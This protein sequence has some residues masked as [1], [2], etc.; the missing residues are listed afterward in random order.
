MTHDM[1]LNK[2][3]FKSR[4]QINDVTALG[5]SL[6][7]GKRISHHIEQLR[8]WHSLMEKG[9]ISHLQFQALQETIFIVRHKTL[10]TQ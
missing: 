2:P 4:K 6:S 10:A 5:K 9:A 1:P 8:K 7:P 3:F